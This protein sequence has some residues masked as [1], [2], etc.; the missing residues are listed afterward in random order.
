MPTVHVAIY[1]SLTDSE[2]GHLLV[3]LRTGRF[4]GTPFDVVTVAESLEPVTTMGGL[5]LVPDMLIGDLDPASSDLLV[6]PGAFLWDEGRGEAFTEAAARFLAAGV[7]VAAI[8][9]A[10]AGLARA[11]L[12]DDRRHTSAA[13]EYLAATGYAG[14]ERYEDARAVADRGLV[15]AGPDAPV[16]FARATLALLGLMPQA[17]LEA[18]EGLFADG[19]ASCF[20]VLM[21][22]AGSP[23][24]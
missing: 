22:A 13:R 1:E 7:P 5:R 23:G 3:E 16:Q 15:T 17:A 12:L 9:G 2:A 6:L 8:C 21:Q 4:T 11:G 18:Y 24:S 10:T 20:P 14:G 19:D